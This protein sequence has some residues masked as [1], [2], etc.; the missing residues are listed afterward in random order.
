LPH[1]ASRIGLIDAS[2]YFGPFCLA[3]R[4]DRCQAR[5][6]ARTCRIQASERPLA[7]G[8]SIGPMDGMTTVLGEPTIPPDNDQAD[9]AP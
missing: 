9:A 2:R 8:A 5:M 7:A 1:S 6:D 4:L 3:Y